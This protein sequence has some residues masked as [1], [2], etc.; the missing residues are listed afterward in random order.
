MRQFSYFVNLKNEILD[1][2]EDNKYGLNNFKLNH[3]CVHLDKNLEIRDVNIDFSVDKEYNDITIGEY[4]SLKDLYSYIRDCYIDENLLFVSLITTKSKTGGLFSDNFHKIDE[5]KLLPKNASDFAFSFLFD[6]IFENNQMRCKNFIL[7]D[8]TSNIDNE[9]KKQINLYIDELNK[10]SDKDFSS[11]K[12][13]ILDKLETLQNLQDYKQKI[14]DIHDAFNHNKPNVFS[15]DCRIDVS[16]FKTTFLKNIVGENLPDLFCDI[17]A[18]ENI[19]V[20]Y[21]LSILDLS[22]PD[23]GDLCNNELDYRVNFPNDFSDRNDIFNINEYFIPFF[24]SEEHIN[25]NLSISNGKINS[26]YYDE[27]NIIFL[28]HKNNKIGYVKYGKEHVTN[29]NEL[30]KKLNFLIF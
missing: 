28:N 19:D 2:L 22:V 21:L 15:Y 1:F 9:T 27:N 24:D 11:L 8:K 6:L 13:T 25:F 29:I 5:N 17:K 10:I 4:N 23:F 14:Y 7:K 16:N 30:I 18:I 20:R 12:Y 3:M 26:C